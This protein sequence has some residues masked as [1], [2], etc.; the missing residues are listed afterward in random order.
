MIAG[1]QLK[2]SYSPAS[3]SY[4]L[5]FRCEKISKNVTFNNMITLSPRMSLTPLSISA[6]ERNP[7]PFGSN[8]LNM[9]DRLAFSSG[10]VPTGSFAVSA[11]NDRRQIQ[12]KMASKSEEVAIPTCSQR[13][14]ASFRA[15]IFQISNRPERVLPAQKCLVLTVLPPPH[16]Q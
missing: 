1:L 2:R 5:Q 14:L 11:L 15:R 8:C 7:F 3:N 13:W 9:S 16:T 12:C 6:N 10:L 4:P